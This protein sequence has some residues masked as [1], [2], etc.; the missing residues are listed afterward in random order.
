MRVR[1]A[2]SKADLESLVQTTH[3]LK[4][5]QETPDSPEALATIPSLKLAICLRATK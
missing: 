1:A 3:A 4:Q 2:M 5:L